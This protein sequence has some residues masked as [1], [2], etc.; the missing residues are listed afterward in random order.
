MAAHAGVDGVGGGL[1]PVDEDLSAHPC[2]EPFVSR[3]LA[4]SF[5]LPPRDRRTTASDHDGDDT[6]DPIP[7]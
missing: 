2:W 7:R 4:V 5:M 1:F 6:H 3:A